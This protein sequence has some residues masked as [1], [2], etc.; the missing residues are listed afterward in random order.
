M[1]ASSSH[2]MAKTTLIMLAC[3]SSAVRADPSVDDTSVA[4]MLKAMQEQMAKLED[5]VMAKDETIASLTAALQSKTEHRQVQLTAGGEVM[6]L[7]SD[8]GFKEVAARVATCEKT[9]ADLDAKL[10]MTMD[11]LVKVRKEVKDARV[12]APPALPPPQPVATPGRRLQ[13]SSNGDSVNELSITGPKAVTSWN[14]RTPGRTSFN[15]TGVGDGKLTCSG[16]MY[17]TNF[18]TGQG[19]SVDMIAAQLA[20]LNDSVSTVLNDSVSTVLEVGY[21]AVALPTFTEHV[22]QIRMFNVDVSGNIVDGWWRA[23]DGNYQPEYE[24]S[25]A[26]LQ[27]YWTSLTAAKV[28]CANWPECTAFWTSDV[29]AGDGRWF[30]TGATAGVQHWSET[31]R[32]D[33]TARTVTYLKSPLPSPPPP[34]PSPPSPPSAP[35]APPA[36]PPSSPPPARYIFMHVGHCN[37]GYYE[38]VDLGARPPASNE[39]N[40][41]EACYNICLIDPLCGYFGY[42]FDHSDCSKY[43]L[44]EGCPD[45]DTYNH[46]N[47]YRI[48]RTN[49]TVLQTGKWC[50]NDGRRY[51]SG[52]QSAFLA[53]EQDAGMATSTGSGYGD[54]VAEEC[55]TLVANDPACGSTWFSCGQHP[56]CTCL[57]PGSECAFSSGSSACTVGTIN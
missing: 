7:V 33:N 15:C 13:S 17:A 1:S 8:A 27:C 23:E 36:Q 32:A 40:N 42:T 44:A 41:L 16:E 52:L 21:S 47:S 48:V 28:N 54:P 19:N 9:T 50:D 22:G 46:Y 5:R 6:Q 53:G 51:Y 39:N 37:G 43:T 45:D 14:S 30:A 55:A 2:K 31:G 20:A 29:V 49:W 10:G 24:C 12:N 18:V 4:A 56:H 25:I 35:P 26:N 3:S 38:T 34:S 57:Q 11:T